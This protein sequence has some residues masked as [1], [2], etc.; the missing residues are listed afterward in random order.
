MEKNS[1]LNEIITEIFKINNKIRFISIIDLKGKIILSE[2]K[3]DLN[4][5][6]KKSNEEKFCEHVAIRRKMRHE[7]DTN[8]GKVN[9]VHVERENVTQIVVYS[10][11]HSFFITVE[12]EITS[13]VKANITM[14]IKE[15]V[16][17]LK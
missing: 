6:L 13:S 14:K 3:S 12:P 16:L 17:R 8:L 15:I 10:K 4:S 9:Y 1:K 7:F 5:L 2:M 11:T